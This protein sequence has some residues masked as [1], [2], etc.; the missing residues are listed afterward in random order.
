MKRDPDRER[1]H[2]NYALW[3][4]A[5]QRLGQ[6]RLAGYRAY[7]VDLRVQGAGGCTGSVRV[8]I[9]PGKHPDLSRLPKPGEGPSLHVV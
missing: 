1:T 3:S 6:L 5:R 9:E 4:L 7:A 8:F 2:E